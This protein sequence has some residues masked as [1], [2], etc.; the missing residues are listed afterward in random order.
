MTHAIGKQGV[1]LRFWT[2]LL[3]LEGGCDR[4]RVR[5]RVRVMVRVRVRVGVQSGFMPVAKVEVACMW[6]NS[7]PLGHPL[8]FSSLGHPLLFSYWFLHE[9][10]RNT[11]K[12]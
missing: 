4:V 11:L 2:R 12:V 6:S 7:M 5:V 3:F 1:V 8:L 9:L 10:C